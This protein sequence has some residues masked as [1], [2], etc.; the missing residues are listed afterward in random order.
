MITK[1]KDIEFVDNSAIL[2]IIVQ[3]SNSFIIFYTSSS[4]QTFE[5]RIRL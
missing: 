4:L 5:K 1:E 3:F 2:E